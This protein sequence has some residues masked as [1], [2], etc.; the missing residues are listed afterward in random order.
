MKNDKQ[1]HPKTNRILLNEQ[2][3]YERLKMC[4]KNSTKI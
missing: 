4:T 2:L 1:N 3:K